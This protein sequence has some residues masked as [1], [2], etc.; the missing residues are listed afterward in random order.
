MKKDRQPRLPLTYYDLLRKKRAPIL[1]ALVE[2]DL[3]SSEG[4]EPEPAGSCAALPNAATYVELLEAGILDESEWMNPGVSREE[5]R[6]VIE[7]SPEFEQL[8]Y[9]AELDYLTAFNFSL[10]GKRTFYITPGLAEH[11]AHTN[12]NVPSDLIRTPFKTCLFV[13]TDALTIN[14]FYE[15]HGERP[16][17]PKDPLNVFLI[18]RP[19]D[20]GLRTLIFFCIHAGESGSHMMVKR[21]LLIREDWDIEKML[22]T[23]WADIYKL[24]EK[25]SFDEGR[26]IEDGLLFFRIVLNVLLYLGSSEPDVMKCLSPRGTSEPAQRSGKWK[27]RQRRAENTSELSFTAVGANVGTIKVA[28]PDMNEPGGAEPAYRIG[29]RFMVRGHWRQQPFGPQS[30]LR[31]LVWI[32]PHFKGPEMA[33]LVN[34]PYDVR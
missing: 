2:D 30:S 10:F 28:K 15:I 22:A 19:T 1:F 21:Q 20:D 25:G 7:T 13:F 33:D 16:E 5:I 11:L 12:L 34:R 32:K 17:A 26:F 18:E 3:L 24:D 14:A 4:T 9:Q 27:K 31:R 23:D 29:T 6:D 8:S